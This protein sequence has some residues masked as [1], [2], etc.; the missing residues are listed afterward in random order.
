MWGAIVFSSL[1]VGA[2]TL[3]AIAGLLLVRRFVDHAYLKSHHE[4][5]GYLL[6]VIG[7]LYAVLLAFVVVDAQSNVQQARQNAEAEANSVVDI[8]H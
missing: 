5:A 3:L 7:T 2:S 8:F 4:V 1:V 6:S